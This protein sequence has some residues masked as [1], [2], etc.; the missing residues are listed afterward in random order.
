M[1]TASWIAPKADCH[2]QQYFHYM[3]QKGEIR[4][5]QAH[6]GYTMSTDE[7]GFAQLNPLYM[8]YTPGPSVGSALTVCTYSVPCTH[9]ED[10]CGK[11]SLRYCPPLRVIHS[12]LTVCP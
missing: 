11:S 1:Y 8:K 6:R 9:D 5:D 2:T 12:G 7:A 10:F 4:A 3:G